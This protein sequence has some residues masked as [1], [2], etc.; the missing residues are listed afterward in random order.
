[1]PAVETGD[2]GPRLLLGAILGAVG[3]PAAGW[4]SAWAGAGLSG[5][6]VGLA[7]AGIGGVVG[8][9][10]WP[11]LTNANP[12]PTR[13][14]SVGFAALFAGCAGLLSGTAAA[15]PIGAIVG[16]LGGAFGGAAAA[17]TWRLGHGLGLGPRSGLAGVVGMGVALLAAVVIAS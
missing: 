4:G 6:W 3:G 11:W 2:R 13:R 16:S 12:A 10:A 15:F 8:C 5:L 17:G 14:P 1:M 7:A 9:L